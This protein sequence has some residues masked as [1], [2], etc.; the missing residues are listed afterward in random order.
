MGSLYEHASIQ[1]RS[2][3]EAAHERALI[4][5]SSPGTWFD[6]K[7]RIEIAKEIRDATSCQLCRNRK[8]ALSP[9][10]IDGS[11]D[12][13]TELKADVV[14]L[15]HRLVTDPARVTVKTY[16]QAIDNG[17][18]D[19]EYVEIV[20]LIASVM[21]IDTVGFGIACDPVPLPTPQPGKPSRKRPLGA[22]PGLAWMPTLAPE[23]AE[24]A[25][26]EIFPGGHKAP[27]IRRALSLVPAEVVGFFDL[28]DHQY[29]PTADMWKFDKRLRAISNSQIELV[30]ARVSAMNECF[31]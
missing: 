1:V 29:L 25:E 28:T 20:G 13:V 21:A 3:L 16:Q 30:A 7:S 9:T 8:T 4:R 12:T 31:Y 27:N 19:G 23:D 26:L 11:H 18:T 15:V 14:D 6:G 10:A 5:I 22:K 2:D 24:G 17:L